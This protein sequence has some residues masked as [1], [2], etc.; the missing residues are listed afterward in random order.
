MASLGP[1]LLG[2]VLVVGLYFALANVGNWRWHDWDRRERILFRPEQPAAPDR[3]RTAAQAIA[4]L[5]GLVAVILAM[6]T[7]VE[8]W[9]FTAWA[10]GAILGLLRW[11]DSAPVP[12]DRPRA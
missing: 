9:A 6:W 5:G 1:S 12:T 7:G 3:R 10:A 2:G 8:A 11:A 4:L